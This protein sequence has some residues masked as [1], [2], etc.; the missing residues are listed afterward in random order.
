MLTS[1]I[2]KNYS[3]LL[4]SKNWPKVEHALLKNTRD[5]KNRESFDNFKTILANTRKAL[6]S[7]T[8]MQNENSR[9]LAW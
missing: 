4:S 5:F 6:V 7:D 8:T 1:S 9:S 2:N 3:A